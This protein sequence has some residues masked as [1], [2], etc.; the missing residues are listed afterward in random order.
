MTRTPSRSQTRTGRREAGVFRPRPLPCYNGRVITY[1]RQQ[2]ERQLVADQALWRRVPA[3]T[4]A[5]LWPLEIVLL[6]WPTG[7]WAGLA[8]VVALGVAST[9]VPPHLRANLYLIDLL[10]RLIALP[11]D[12]CWL[13]LAWHLW[14]REPLFPVFGQPLAGAVVVTASLVVLTRL[15]ALITRLL[16]HQALS[17]VRG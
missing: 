10:E 11:L 9:V 13:L 4:T 7:W 1:S 3:A 5:I 16:A 12:L 15:V 14:V 8:T 2:M 6:G 17:G